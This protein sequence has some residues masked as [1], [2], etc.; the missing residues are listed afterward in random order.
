MPLTGK[1]RTVKN[2][3]AIPARRNLGRTQP[4]AVGSPESRPFLPHEFS[5]EGGEGDLLLQDLAG[6]PFLARQGPRD[7][8]ILLLQA[9]HFTVERRRELALADPFR[10]DHDHGITAAGKDAP[11]SGKADGKGQNQQ[12]NDDQQDKQEWLERRSRMI[13]DVQE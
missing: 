2:V 8:G 9:G 1:L 11:G 10:A 4:R 7:A 13:E 3:V 5:G 12:D 6:E